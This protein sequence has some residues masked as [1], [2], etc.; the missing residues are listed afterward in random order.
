MRYFLFFLFLNV[1]ALQAQTDSV[2]L[3]D[4]QS[5]ECKAMIEVTPG[6]VKKEMV[7]DTTFIRLFC[8]NNCAGYH[9]PS[10]SLSGDSVLITIHGGELL[11][12][13]RKFYL[14][15]NEWINEFDMD[16]LEW[17]YSKKII[18]TDSTI[19]M[20]ENLVMAICDCCYNFELKILGLDSSLTYNYFYNGRYIDPNYKTTGEIKEYHFPYFLETPQYEVFEKLKKII[21]K[22]KNKALL[23]ELKSFPLI[24]NITADTINYSIAQI[25]I[26]Y[27]NKIKNTEVINRKIT[28]YLMSK[29]AMVLVRNHMKN[30]WIKE[31]ILYFG[32]NWETEDKL[33]MKFEAGERMS[34]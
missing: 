15:D 12:E 28:D 1:F 24:I 27:V 5:S 4:I 25:E 26:E 21:Y 10:V 34:D 20:T 14:V 16:E 32:F 17:G 3:V 33:E 30:R 8:S 9:N 2:R 29:S 7:G 19:R 6:F 11:M 31:Y 22:S 18:P 13:P 23:K